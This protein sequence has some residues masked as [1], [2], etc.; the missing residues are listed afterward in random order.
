MHL[1][2][3]KSLYKIQL[4]YSPDGREKKALE[5]VRLLIYE[6]HTC[7]H[8]NYPFLAPYYNILMQKIA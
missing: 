5:K 3:G 2:E 6:T 7:Q 8:R 4:I 1:I